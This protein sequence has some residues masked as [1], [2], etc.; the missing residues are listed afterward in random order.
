M[1]LVTLETKEA[2][3]TTSQI[4]THEEI[5]PVRTLDPESYTRLIYLR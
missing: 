3:S 5:R 2:N 4:T 1:V